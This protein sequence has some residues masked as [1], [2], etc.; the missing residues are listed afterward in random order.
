MTEEFKEVKSRLDKFVLIGDGCW[1]WTGYLNN[2]GY[3]KFAFRGRSESAHR[4]SFMLANNL[5]SLPKEFVCHT[6]DNP[7]CVRPDHL[8]TG[9]RTDN[10][11][12][13]VR[14]GR[15]WNK[16][17]TH[18]KYGHE[19]SGDNVYI[20]KKGRACRTCLNLTSKLFAQ[21]RRRLLGIKPKSNPLNP[22]KG[23]AYSKTYREKK[24]A[25]GLCV[26]GCGNKF[27]EGGK[28]CKP[29][30]VKQAKRQ[31]EKY[32]QSKLTTPLTS[33]TDCAKV[34]G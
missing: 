11:R 26:N 12:D 20:H 16:K 1:N 14:K 7:K 28:Y 17:K 3:G 2:K 10:M 33:I 29:C 24:L 8:F 5:E 23:S 34:N 6:C 31:L 9:T 22:S 4:V 19:L 13:M 25:A 15:H 18:C 21:K 32:H 30:M 27:T